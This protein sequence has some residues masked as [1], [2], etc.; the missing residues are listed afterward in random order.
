MKKEGDPIK[1]GD[2]LASIETDKATVDFEMQEEGFIAKLLYPAG[3]KDVSIGTIVAIV[4]ENQE[5]VAK[6]KDFKLEGDAA[7]ATSAPAQDAA[8]P[9]KEEAQT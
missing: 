8:A 4:V 9:K 1:P 6:F 3:T 7:P 2:L 5:D